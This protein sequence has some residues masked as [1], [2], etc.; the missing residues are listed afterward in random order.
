MVTGGNFFAKLVGSTSSEGFLVLLVIISTTT[1]VRYDVEMDALIGDSESRRGC[2]HQPGG[3]RH[4]CQSVSRAV[5]TFPDDVIEQR[6]VEARWIA[7]FP[8]GGASTAVF[9]HS[10]YRS[11]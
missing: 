5:M 2:L 10:C 6:S 9:S 8:V 11:R 7:V 1:G 4:D 3:R